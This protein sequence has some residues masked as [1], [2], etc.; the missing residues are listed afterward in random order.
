MP[1]RDT[2]HSLLTRRKLT[3]AIADLVKAEVKD[4][5]ATLTPLFQPQLVFGDHVEGGMRGSPTRRAD[6]AIKEVQAAYETIS[7]TKPFNLR[8]ELNVPFGL[9]STTLEISPVEYVHAAS[10][11]TGERQILVRKPLMWAVSYAGYTP[12]RLPEL[13][14]ARVRGEE[15]Q[16]FIVSHLA[17]QQ[18][19]QH[20]TGLSR[21][22]DAMHLRLGTTKMTALGD[23]PV[24]CIALAVGTELPPDDVILESADLTGMDS[25]EEIAR[26]ED[27][28]ALQDGMKERLRAIVAA[29]A[30]Q[31]LTT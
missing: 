17:L 4:H 2:I 28:D 12:A 6:Q 20:Q 25:F 27:I 23:L 19:I 7:P 15:L 3:R 31:P 11:P 22:F 21:L 30:A 13:L 14:D 1:E 29:Q 5:L 26:A 9:P 16:R 8:R 10:S 24:N 18:V